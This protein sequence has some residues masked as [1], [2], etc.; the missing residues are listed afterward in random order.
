MAAGAR[1]GNFARRVLYGLV[2]AALAVV[3]GAGSAYWAVS[4]RFARG[5]VTVGPWATNENVGSSAADPYLRAGIAIGGLLALAKEETVYFTATTD[6]DGAPL[7]SSCVYRVDGR[8]PDARW[9]SITAYAT[10]HYLIPNDADRYS[11]DK[12]RVV[13]GHEG[14][15]GRFTIRVGGAATADAN[16]IPTGPADP[17]Q[18]FSLTLRMY[19]PAPEV[20]AD[21]AAAALPRIVKEG[22]A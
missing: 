3:L 12:T 9:W 20:V 10:D 8:D 13:R 14:D 2:F 21:L 16:W 6:G 11:V 15:A 22:C 18:R 19:D 7:V 1:G 5:G 4:R 17:P